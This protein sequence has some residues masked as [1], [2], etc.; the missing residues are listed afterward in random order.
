M[1]EPVRHHFDLPRANAFLLRRVG[2]QPE[3][4]ESSGICTR[5]ASESWFSHRAQGPDTGRFGAVIAIRD[6]PPR[7]TGPILSERS[8]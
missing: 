2:L 7:P 1:D 5:C 4:I 3:N 8:R 6:A